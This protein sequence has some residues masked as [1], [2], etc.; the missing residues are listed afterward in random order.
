MTVPFE[1]VKELEED[2]EARPPLCCDDVDDVDERFELQRESTVDRTVLEVTLNV[3]LAVV[4]AIAAAAEEANIRGGA[5]VLDTGR[6]NDGEVG[7]G[8]CFDRSTE[9]SRLPQDVYDIEDDGRFVSFVTS[10]N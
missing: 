3:T 10:V 6:L 4:T 7:D 5:G 2:E 8:E 9:K 1:V